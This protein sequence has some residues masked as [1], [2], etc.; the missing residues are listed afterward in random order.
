MVDIRES[1][2]RMAPQAAQAKPRENS[3]EEIYLCHSPLLILQWLLCGDKFRT[4]KICVI[5][6]LFGLLSRSQIL[7]H[8]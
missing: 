1:V 4:W 8:T 3:S 6:V 7:S 2:W 5:L